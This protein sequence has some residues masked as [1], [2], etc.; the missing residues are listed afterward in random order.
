MS[1]TYPAGGSRRGGRGQHGFTL[2]EVLVALIVLA[3][4]LLG[5]AQLQARGLKFNQDAY[6][7]SQATTLAYEIIDRMRANRDNAALYEFDDD[8]GE[9]GATPLAF[10]NRAACNPALSTPDNDLSCW[11]D[12]IE[13]TLPGGKASIVRQGATSPYYDVTIEWNDRETNTIKRQ[14]WTTWP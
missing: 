4:G 9:P 11:Y 8:D 3:I 5:L 12:H 1:M 6:V 7:R 10:F 14:T 13:G 2:V